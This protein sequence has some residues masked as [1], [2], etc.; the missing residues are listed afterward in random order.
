MNLL[1]RLIT[2]RKVIY[3]VEPKADIAEFIRYVG[4]GYHFDSAGLEVSW[5]YKQV[6]GT[7]FDKAAEYLE[8]RGIEVVPLAFR[9]TETRMKALEAIDCLEKA[10]E[11]SE[12]FLEQQARVCEHQ[13]AEHGDMYF[14]GANL[15]TYREALQILKSGKKESIEKISTACHRKHMLAQVRESNPQLIVVN[16]AHADY[17]A[18]ELPEYS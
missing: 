15:E 11:N 14:T 9:R 12:T 13:I 5:E 4:R 17:L 18:R 3:P 2:K 10:G 16:S 8:Q 1:K 7:F 6:R